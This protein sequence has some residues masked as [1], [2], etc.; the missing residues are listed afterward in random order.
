MRNIAEVLPR[1]DSVIGK[2]GTRKRLESNVL[3]ITCA[4][5]IAVILLLKFAF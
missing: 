4:F 1:V 3:M 2:I 5:C